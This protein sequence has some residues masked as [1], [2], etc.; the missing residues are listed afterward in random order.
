MARKYSIE[1]IHDDDQ[2]A[3]LYYNDDN[4]LELVDADTG[5]LIDY[6]QTKLDLTKKI[7]EFMKSYKMKK[8]ECKKV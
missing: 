2:M 6:L 7:V 3:Q 4:T 1:V 5:T 8:L